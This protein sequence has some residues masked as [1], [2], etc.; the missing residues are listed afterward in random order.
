MRFSVL[1]CIALHFFVVPASASDDARQ[2]PLM[3]GEELPVERIG[4]APSTTQIVVLATMSPLDVASMGQ[5]G[6]IS[7]QV[8]FCTSA[9]SS[10]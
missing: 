4:E 7:C 1:T 10:K 3:G 5:S 6:L 2:W 9:T 8:E